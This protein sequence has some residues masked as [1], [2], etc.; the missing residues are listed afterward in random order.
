MLT[1]CK[2]LPKNKSWGGRYN[3]EYSETTQNNVSAHRAAYE[4]QRGSIPPGMFV[5]HKCDV[6]ACVNI[7]HLFLGTHADNMQ[8]MVRKGRHREQQKKA[9]PKGHAYSGDNLVLKSDG[10]RRCRECHRSGEAAR[11]ARRQGV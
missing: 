11:K 10:S 5:L 6:P 4:K 7:E 9:C 8:D 3:R 2:F 1:P